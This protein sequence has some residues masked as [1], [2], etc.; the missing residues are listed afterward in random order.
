MSDLQG[1]KR[2]RKYARRRAAVLAA[3]YL[4]MGAHFA[5][6]WWAGKTVTPLEV[7]ETMHTLE[8]GVLTCGFILMAAA[9]LSTLVVGRF[10]C[11]WGCHIL[12]LEDASNWILRKAGIR[13]KPVRSRLM[14]LVPPVAALYMFVWPQVLRL[15]EGRAH[16]GLSVWDDSTSWASFVTEN[17]WRSMPGPWVSVLTLFVCGFAVVYFLGS[18]SFCSYAC[19][20][21]AV[22]AVADRLAP[23]RIVVDGDCT[24][25]GKCTAA[26]ET[27]IRVHEELI[28][29]GHLVNPSCLKA[30][31]CVDA[32]P[33]GAVRF[34]FAKPALFRSER[35]VGR[36]GVPYDFT[37]FEDVL[38][39][40]VFVAGF[41]AFRGLY[42]AIPFLLTLALAGILGLIALTAL[43]LVRT[44]NVRLVPF[45]LKLAG[46]VTGAG[47]AFGAIAT[48]VLGLAAHS[49]FIR[50]HETAGA[51]ELGALE[52]AA[53]QGVPPDPALLG[54][55]LGHLEACARFGLVRPVKLDE[56]LATAYLLRDDYDAAEPHV[57]AVLAE[58]PE[59]AEWRMRLAALHLTRNRVVEAIADLRAITEPNAD[60]EQ[61]LPSQRAA[62]H[63]LLAQ[64]RLAQDDVPGAARE[65]EAA[66]LAWPE[67]PTARAALES[68]TQSP[69]GDA[70]R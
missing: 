35:T 68:L 25:C 53:K 63:E 34:G 64:I 27:H 55:A 39:G 58:R 13:P 61:V 48:L 15:L 43:R 26:C 12:A 17:Y 70:V 69:G 21:G 11:S 10:F 51:N 22:F 29:F 65:L 47:W 60:G 20:Y 33:T 4:L 3:I 62:A 18:R 19:P 30:M 42:D 52:A 50:Y 6:W 7:S 38:L 54:K 57:K 37:L 16:P 14:L 45:Q 41:F 44:A 59:A 46:R 56:R 2:P 36:F 8:L 5:H 23:G 9:I 32:C 67:S 24:Q 49:G 1:D 40:L 66:L 28:Q 31:D